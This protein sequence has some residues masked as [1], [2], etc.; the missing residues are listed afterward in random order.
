MTIH[1]RDAAQFNDNELVANKRGKRIFVIFSTFGEREAGLIY[2]KISLIDTLKCVDAIFLSHRRVDEHQEESTELKA[3]QA[4]DKT[5]VIVCNTVQVPDMG[6]EKGKGA[7]MRRALYHIITHYKPVL[8]DTIIVFLDADVIP[9]YFGL[10][11]VLGLVGAVLQGFDFAKASFWREMGRVK[12]YVAQPLFSAIVHEDLL[13][14]R[15]LAYPLSGEVAGTLEFFTKVCFWQMYGVETGINIDAVLG[16]YAIADVNL[17]LYDHEH[18][19]DTNI[20]KMSFGIIRTFLRQLI[21]YGY[22]EL[23]KGAAVS[24]VF[25]AQYIDEQ[26]KRQSMK[27]DLQEKKYDPLINIIL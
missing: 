23:K 20:Q 5:T 2:Q 22:V 4:S 21:D 27:F 7:D 12:K 13:D 25:E 9:Q 17:G 19:G 26:G 3:K 16:K 11:F 6:N 14:L 10:H 15:T 18:H 1:Q 24:D 8:Q